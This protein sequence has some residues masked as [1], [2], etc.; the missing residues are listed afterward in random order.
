MPM[1]MAMVA[2]VALIFLEP[3]ASWLTPFCPKSIFLQHRCRLEY[4]L[5]FWNCLYSS[6]W[7]SM[8]P[9]WFLSRLFCVGFDCWI[10]DTGQTRFGKFWGGAMGT[11][12]LFWPHLCKRVWLTVIHSY[13]SSELL[14]SWWNYGIDRHY[15]FDGWLGSLEAWASSPLDGTGTAPSKI[16]CAIFKQAVQ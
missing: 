9:L 2:V 12:A 4:C 13:I 10:V 16:A 5:M 11:G 6:L 14:R 1:A 8:Q 7:R 3:L 15:E